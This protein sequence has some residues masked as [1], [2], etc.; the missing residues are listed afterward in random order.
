TLRLWVNGVLTG[1]TAI[2][3][4]LINSTGALRMGGNSIWNEWYAGKI[5]EPH[6]Y[7]RALTQAEIQADMNRPIRQTGPD[8]TPPAVAITAPANGAAVGGNVT[9]TASASD[10]VAVT[11]VQFKLDGANLG[12]EGTSPYSIT[13]D[14]TSVPNG[15]HLISAV[16]RDTAGNTAT[17]GNVSVTVSNAAPPPP[18][19][20]VAA[21][22]LNETS[23][24]RAADLSGKGNIGTTRN[25]TW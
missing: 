4:T 18:T 10:D 20:L 21:Y 11:G 14:S 6:V 15:P 3:G 24:T 12:A 19:G 25:V 1:S 17:S 23:G 13:W 9:V 7:N 16:S 8:T 2:T 5:D 22:G